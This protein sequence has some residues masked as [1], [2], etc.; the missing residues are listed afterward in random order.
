MS[1]LLGAIGDSS[2]YAYRGNLDDVPNDFNFTNVTN[3]NPGTGYTSGPVTITGINNKILVSVSAGASI[4][5]NSGIFTSGPGFIRSGET[6]ALYT[7]TTSGSDA[8]FNKSYTVTATV[9]KTLKSWNVTTRNKDVVPNSFSFNNISNLELGI[10]TTS[11]TVTISGLE[12]TLPSNASIISGVG[13]FSKNGGTPGTASTIGNGDTISITSAGPIDYSKT[14]TTTIRVGTFTTTFSVSTRASDT[15][16]DQFIFNNLTNVGIDSSYDSNSVTL[17]GADTNTSSAPV[18]LTASVSGGFLKVV[19]GSETVR[20]FSISTATVYNGDILT[21]K[22]NA[23]P[24]YSTSTSAVLTITGVNTPVGV[25]STF[26]VTTRPIISDT[27]PDQFTFVDKTG[28]GRNIATISDPIT[29]S[30]ITT[31]ADDFATAFLS[32]NVDNGEF[33]V[34]RN[35]TV[36]RD[37]GTDSAQVRDGDLIDL[38]ITTSPASNGS[39]QT[40]L[41]VSG[42]DNTDIENI[43]SQTINDTWVVE[44][45]TR[46]CPL[47][48]PD[49][50]DITKAEPSSLQSVTFIPTSYDNDCNVTVNTSNENSYLDVNGTTGNDLTVLPGV[51]CTI[52]MTAGDFSD[53]R[54]TTITLTANNNIPTITSTST[55]WSVTTRNINTPTINLSADPSSIT[56]GE[57]TELTWE[58]SGAVSITTDGFSV[59]GIT[60]G[61]STTVGPLKDSKTYSVTAT[62]TDGTTSTSSVTVDV[63]TTASATLTADTDYVEYNGSVTLTWNTSN[64]S[65]VVSNFG[66]TD[67]S[68]STTLYNLKENQ[69]YTLRAVSNNGCADSATQ[70]VNV[71]VE[72]CVKTT[73]QEYLTDTLYMDFTYGNAGNGLTYYFSTLSGSGSNELSRE[74]DFVDKEEYWDGSWY[75]GRTDFDWTIPAGVTEIYAEAKGAGGGGGGGGPATPGGGGGGGALAYGTFATAPGTNIRLRLG[76]SGSGGPANGPGNTSNN[77]GTFGT[78]GGTGQGTVISYVA[79]DGGLFELLR[80]RGGYGG[81]R[82]IGGAGGGTYPF[83][84]EQNYNGEPV[85]NVEYHNQVFQRYDLDAGDWDY[86]EGGGYV[87]PSYSLLEGG[88][89]YRK[90]GSGGGYGSSGSSGSGGTIYLNYFQPKEA[91][92]WNTLVNS[93]NNQYESSFNRPAT[94][95]EM[96]YWITVYIDYTYDT[97][98]QIT[99]AIAGSGAYKSSGGAVDECGA[100]I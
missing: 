81:G 76:P 89:S 64:A 50:A 10:T 87:A 55:T 42:T 15:T 56:C 38:R 94:Y 28:Q 37:F 32:N 79:P 11:N 30:G 45:A 97:V 65:S 52:Y 60:T 48:A 57:E 36:V 2:E 1:P 25:S 67:T 31:H 63:A 73:Y 84:S 14:N 95:D 40:R 18:N 3:A 86:G 99:T 12:S 17:T 88:N 78:P 13:S 41:N 70:T 29:L 35:G 49:L 34:T 62:G 80:G 43:V 27:I 92:D 74:V 5:I 83:L 6:I 16:V 85:N 61:G 46:N 20:D 90:G 68:G 75:G 23:S 26:T 4:A 33:R 54:T 72:P 7:S 59:T 53:V 69:S 8:D 19:R 51:A 24:S 47:E 66:V 98:S 21:L 93:V 58:S 9:G 100:A 77:S 44:S 22:L 82:G 39:V 71:E 96:I 91:A